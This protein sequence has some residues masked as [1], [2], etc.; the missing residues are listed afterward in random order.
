MTTDREREELQRRADDAIHSIGNVT[1][2][3]ER[4]GLRQNLRGI[5]KDEAQS[6]PYIAEQCTAAADTIETLLRENEHLRRIDN[7][8]EDERVRLRRENEAL[9]LELTALKNTE[10]FYRSFPEKLDDH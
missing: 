5:A 4:E 1:T 9:R 2:D 3:R 8:W 6:D 7:H 10:F